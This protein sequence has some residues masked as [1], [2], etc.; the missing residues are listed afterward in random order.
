MSESAIASRHA[1]VVRQ[2]SWR[3]YWK[4]KIAFERTK[5]ANSHCEL[6]PG[7]PACGG[8]GFGEA[9][10]KILHDHRHYVA[11]SHAT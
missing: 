10:L 1:T 11:F 3:S 4:I 6:Q 9:L 5:V 2:C 8:A 7:A